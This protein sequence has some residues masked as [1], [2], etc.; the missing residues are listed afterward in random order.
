[1]RLAYVRK[2]NTK[3]TKFKYP[4]QFLQHPA[5]CQPKFPVIGRVSGQHFSSIESLLSGNKDIY[6]KTHRL[7]IGA[8]HVCC[9]RSGAGSRKYHEAN[10]LQLFLMKTAT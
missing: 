9:P 7:Y 5:L 2:I 4:L 3:P 10:A 1:V 8:T 6:G